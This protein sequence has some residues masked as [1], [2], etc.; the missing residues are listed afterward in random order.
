LVLGSRFFGQQRIS[1][2][3]PRKGIAAFLL[4]E[5]MVATFGA[6]SATDE[7]RDAKLGRVRL[8]QVRAA[9]QGYDT[10]PEVLT[11]IQEILMWLGGAPGLVDRQGMQ[12]SASTPTYEPSEAERYQ[13]LFKGLM[14]VSG[15]CEEMY[16]KVERLYW[17][18]PTMMIVYLVLNWIMEH[19]K[20]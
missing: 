16:V 6:I 18:L 8:L 5:I 1:R 19:L 7:I 9:K 12:L 11:E 20:W 13:T 10:P 4:D 14:L 2:G 15:R 17:L 3:Y